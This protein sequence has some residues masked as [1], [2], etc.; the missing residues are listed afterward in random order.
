MLLSVGGISAYF[1]STEDATNRWT[2]GNVTIDL[3]E[4]EYDKTP[5]EERE[6]IT[7]NKTFVKDPVVH[8]TGTNDAFVF[9]KF[10]VPKANVRTATL[11]GQVQEAALQ[12]LFSYVINDNWT[13]VTADTSASNKNTYVY[14]YG[15]PDTCTPLQAGEATSALFEDEQVTLINVLEGQGLEGTTLEIPVQAYGIQTADLGNEDVTNP[16][17]VWEILNTQVES[18]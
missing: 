7:P 11:T 12:E 9:I 18:E 17:A 3:T 1:T 4:E 6:D 2:V 15:N 16:G 10:S 14:A 5:P 8:N 13:K